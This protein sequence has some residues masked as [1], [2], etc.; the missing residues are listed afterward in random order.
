[1]EVIL[2]VG[3]IMTMVNT[4]VLIMMA[5]SILREVRYIATRKY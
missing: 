4:M 1:M 3:T 5:P 2:I